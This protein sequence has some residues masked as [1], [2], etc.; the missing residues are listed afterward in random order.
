MDSKVVSFQIV[1]GFA[2]ASSKYWTPDV[3]ALCE[4]GSMWYTNLTQ[5]Q[6]GYGGSWTRMTPQPTSY[7]ASTGGR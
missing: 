3:V 7:P 6:H 1:Q 2:S 4:D 5:F